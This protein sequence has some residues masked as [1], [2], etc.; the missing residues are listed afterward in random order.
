MRILSVGDRVREGSYPAHSS[1]SRALNFMDGRLL[2]SVVDE[3]VGGGPLNIVLSGP[4][5]DAA[6]RL[7]IGARRA[8]LGDVSLDLAAARRYRSELGTARAGAAELREGLAV[9]E[10]RLVETA[11]RESLVFL[12]DGRRVRR[13]RPGFERA[14]A[15]RATLA[16]REIFGGDLSEGARMLKGCGFGLT[17]SGDDFLAGALFG[18]HFLGKVSGGD[19]GRAVA[20]V[21]EAAKGGGVFSDTFLYLAKEGLF[22]ESLKGL[23]RALLDG[24]EEAIIRAADRL[25]AVGA[26]S[27]ADLATGFLMTL[28]KGE[29]LWSSTAG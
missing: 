3:T 26:S 19:F 15:D 7:E 5:P 11:P 2:V 20:L 21:Y 9:L 13:L 1:F 6:D 29:A 16:A 28:R 25:I 27:G 12:L 22:F 8:V 24:A 10:T 17:P 14:F 23:A 18:L 4:L